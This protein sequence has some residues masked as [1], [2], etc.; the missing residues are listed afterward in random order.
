MHF[1]G[2]RCPST[3]RHQ[4]QRDWTGPDL[5]L[6][7]QVLMLLIYTIGLW[8]LCRQQVP[9]SH[10]GGSDAWLFSPLRLAEVYVLGFAVVEGYCAAVHPLVFGGRLPFLPLMLRSLYSAAGV[11]YIWMKWTGAHV[12]ATS[13]FQWT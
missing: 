6:C 7:L 3:T 5:H 11:L 13:S 9:S 8:A 4:L 12:V 1:Y 10:A 2:A